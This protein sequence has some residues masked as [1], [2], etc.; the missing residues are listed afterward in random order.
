MLQK[1]IV[2]VEPAE[3]QRLV[4]G[5]IA[6]LDFIERRRDPNS[7]V[8]EFQIDGAKLRIIAALLKLRD[9]AGISFVLPSSVTEEVFFTLEEASK[10]PGYRDGG[11]V[12]SPDPWMRF[13]RGERGEIEVG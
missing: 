6:E 1:L 11:P 13:R 4:A 7:D 9:A 8:Q 12:T 3:L 5:I 10:E 2:F